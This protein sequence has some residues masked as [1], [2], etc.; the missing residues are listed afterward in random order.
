MD[1]YGIKIEK[2]IPIPTSN[3]ANHD[4]PWK[5]LE[6]G[7]SFLVTIRKGDNFNRL[8]NSIMGAGRNY[9]FHHELHWKFMSRITAEG[10]RIWR[11]E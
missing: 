11:I 7:D 2:N 9:S 8:R 3:K 6:K 10:I 1:N 5:D 4:Y